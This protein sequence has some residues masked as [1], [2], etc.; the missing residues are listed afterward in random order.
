MTSEQ[1]ASASV[2]FASAIVFSYRHK[3]P[4]GIPSCTCMHTET[5]RRP[6]SN[7]NN[8]NDNNNNNNNGKTE[9][10]EKEADAEK[11]ERCTVMMKENN[12]KWIIKMEKQKRDK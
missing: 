8:N 11:E 7:N 3:Y 12:L 4:S 6:H 1:T 10:K 2:V 9:R 5:H